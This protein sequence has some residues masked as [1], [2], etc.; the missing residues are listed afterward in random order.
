MIHKAIDAKTVTCT[1]MYAHCWQTD[2]TL[3]PSTQHS[4]LIYMM[5][6]LTHV[7]SC[8]TTCKHTVI[9][10][11]WTSFAFFHM[12]CFCNWHYKIQ[13][14]RHKPR[15]TF[16]RHCNKHHLSIHVAYVYHMTRYSMQMHLNDVH[17]QGYSDIEPWHASYLTIIDMQS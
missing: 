11:H 5:A 12:T 7:L 1:R 8:N 2:V 17:W 6:L 4:F 13:S 16:L 15:D 9:Q 10:L 3:T 14:Y